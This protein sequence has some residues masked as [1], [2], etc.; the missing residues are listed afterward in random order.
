MSY[1]NQTHPAM[2]TKSTRAVAVISEPSRRG[3]RASHAR[4]ELILGEL[5]KRRRKS[6]PTTLRKMRAGEIFYS[7]DSD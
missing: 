7:S 1:A 5:D 3:L 2:L 6:I 4:V